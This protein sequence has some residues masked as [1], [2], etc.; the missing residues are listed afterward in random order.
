MK[1]LV[2][3]SANVATL[4]AKGDAVGLRAK[5]RSLVDSAHAVRNSLTVLGMRIDTFPDQKKIKPIRDDVA[6]LNREVSWL[7]ENVEVDWIAKLLHSVSDPTD[8]D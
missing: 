1:L 8:R 2:I 6:D 5:L 4:E 3:D 7:L